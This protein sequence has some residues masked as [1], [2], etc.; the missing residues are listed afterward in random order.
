MYIYELAVTL[1][2]RQCI[3][4][5]DE[6]MTR[7]ANAS[8]KSKE[9]QPNAQSQRFAAHLLLPHPHRHTSTNT[10]TENRKDN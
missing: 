8:A 3:N 2:Q 6:Q 9:L 1:N 10:I 7:Q 5:K 4:L